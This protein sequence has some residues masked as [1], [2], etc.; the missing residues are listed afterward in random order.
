MSAKAEEVEE[1]RGARARSAVSIVYRT[2][3]LLVSKLRQALWRW[4]CRW[5]KWPQ[6]DRL[7]STLSQNSSWGGIGLGN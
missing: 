2:D 6:T 4:R 1:E 5:E 7:R 3:K